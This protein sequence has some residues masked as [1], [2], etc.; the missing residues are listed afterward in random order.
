M[1][2]AEKD[3]Q[4]EFSDRFSKEN[5]MMEYY[6]GI[7]IDKNFPLL[8]KINLLKNLDYCHWMDMRKAGTTDKTYEE[9]I[10]G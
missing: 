7:R 4:E 3:N 8:R 5:A 10:K 6:Y 9:L 1:H 2:E